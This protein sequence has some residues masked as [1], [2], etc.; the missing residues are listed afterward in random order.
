M[1]A[2][3]EGE[4]IDGARVE[5]H[6]ELMQQ[7][8]ANVAGMC[9]ALWHIREEETYRAEGHESFGAFLRSIGMGGS[10]GRLH[11]NAGPLLLEL[12]K[13][14]HDARV[15]HVDVLRPVAL[16]LSPKKQSSEV[17]E[18]VIARQAQIIRTAIAVA[19]RGQEP[20][21]ER[22]VARVAERN[23]GIKPRAKYL[24]EKRGKRESEL[25]PEQQRAKMKTDIE[26][27]CSVLLGYQRTGWE[28]KQEI[29][30]ASL[31]V[32]VADA[33]TLLDDWWNA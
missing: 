12:R 1:S 26:L 21:N 16:L 5:R 15:L 10:T 33:R 22:V 31:C 18:R 11:A 14:G 6:A 32:G 23:Y 17:Q 20:F 4:L 19:D 29:G 28:L 24:E 3:M 25:S 13:T 30:E 8:A 2:V 7:F 27:A 9:I